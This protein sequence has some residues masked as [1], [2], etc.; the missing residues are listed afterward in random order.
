MT[1]KKILEYLEARLRYLIRTEPDKF[2]YIDDKEYKFD[3]TAWDAKVCQ[4]EDLID[5]IKQYD[6]DEDVK[7]YVNG[8]IKKYE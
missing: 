8:V 2:E 4:L 5:D 1:T 3:T 6:T 7:V